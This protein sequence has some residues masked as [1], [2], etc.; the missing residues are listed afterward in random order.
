[1]VKFLLKRTDRKEKKI[2]KAVEKRHNLDTPPIAKDVEALV[3]HSV[4]GKRSFGQGELRLIQDGNEILKKALKS[5]QIEE[6]HVKDGLSIFRLGVGM[7]FI[8]PSFMGNHFLNPIKY[9]DTWEG[10]RRIGKIMIFLIMLSYLWMIWYLPQ[11]STVNEGDML[12]GRIALV[13]YCLAGTTIYF[14]WWYGKKT[15]AFRMICHCL[16]PKECDLNDIHVGYYVCEKFPL[17]EQTEWW[18][19]KVVPD[20]LGPLNQDLLIKNRDYQKEVVKLTGQSTASR[21]L[22]VIRAHDH[23]ERNGFLRKDDSILTGYKITTAVFGVIA[24]ALFLYYG[25]G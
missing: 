14:M 19:G 3:D 11:S 1:M 10:K 2:L 8:V 17:A 5:G 21:I 24:L 6:S 9:S 15:T 23:F 25:G 18:T 22:S 20:V 16:H 13:I 12:T 4:E 7:H